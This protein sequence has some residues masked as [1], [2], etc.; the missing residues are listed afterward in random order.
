MVFLVTSQGAAS[1]RLPTGCG[2]GAAQK[3][4]AASDLLLTKK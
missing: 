3:E 2:Q 1:R 4:G